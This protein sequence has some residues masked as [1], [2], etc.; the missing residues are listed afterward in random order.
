MREPEDNRNKKKRKKN[1]KKRKNKQTAQ[2]EEDADVDMDVDEDED[3]DVDVDADAGQVVVEGLNGQAVARRKKRR[4]NAGTSGRQEEE[5]ENEEEEEEDPLGDNP[6]NKSIV[7]TAERA[8]APQEIQQQASNI[9]MGLSS[10]EDHL[11]WA[12]DFVKSIK[13]EPWAQSDALSTHSLAHLADRCHRSRDMSI[14]ATFCHMINDILFSAKINSIMLA[15]K[16]VNPAK[17][18]GIRAAE[19]ELWVKHGFRWARLASAGSI[20][21][22][23]LI[24]AKKMNQNLGDVITS[25]VL[26][27]VCYELRAPSLRDNIVPVV[28]RLQKLLQFTFPT[29]FSKEIRKYYLIENMMNIA[30]IERT[31]HYFDLFLY[32]QPINVPRN[33]YL[34]KEVLQFTSSDN[35][36][37]FSSFNRRHLY[38]ASKRGSEEA[39]DPIIDD[40]EPLSDEEDEKSITQEILSVKPSPLPTFPSMF[41][42]EILCTDSPKWGVLHIIKTRFALQKIRNPF[43]STNK[44]S[45]TEQHRKLASEGER[46]S[47]LEEFAVKLSERYTNQGSIVPN[48]KW[49]HLT[50]TVING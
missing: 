4:V 41:V 31:D 9:L 15:Q 39:V 26:L 50:Q 22:L 3:A 11:D 43:T 17:L 23:M 47:T 48:Q 49:L 12:L 32:R 29:L 1:K 16:I 27:E 25:N 44:K 8:P 24:A 33:E 21:I 18:P 46:P 38:S 35:T 14:F 6:I 36:S 10:S 45:R 20:Y 34:W 30:S 28:A 37:S 19:K 42:G 5:E 13:G 2:T 7:F 40:G